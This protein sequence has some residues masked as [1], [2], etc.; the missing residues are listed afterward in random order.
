[1]R[2]HK[3]TRILAFFLAVVMTVAAMPTQALAYLADK[4][5]GVTIVDKDGNAITEDSSWE[6]TFPYGT[7]AF[8]NSQLTVAEG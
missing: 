3:R 8:G 4:T 5:D 2:T 1:M 7:F 6:E